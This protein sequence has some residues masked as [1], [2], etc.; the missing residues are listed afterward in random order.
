MK[1]N[2]KV[3]LLSIY[4]DLKSQLSALERLGVTED[5]CAVM[6]YALVEFSLPEEP[7]GALQR[8]ASSLETEKP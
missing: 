4:D 7:W 2:Q 6:L 5:K 3:S 1:P 8:Y